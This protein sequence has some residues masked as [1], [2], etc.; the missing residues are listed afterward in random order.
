MRDHAQV[1][2]FVIS[3]AVSFVLIPPHDALFGVTSTISN[4]M[5]VNVVLASKWNVMGCGDFDRDVYIGLV[6]TV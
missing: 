3:L 4:P 1:K 2:Q 5:L 6:F